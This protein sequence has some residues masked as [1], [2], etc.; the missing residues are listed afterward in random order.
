MPIKIAINGFG[1]IGRPSFR[2]ALGSKEFEVAAINDLTDTKTLAHLL[3][4]DSLYGRFGKKVVYDQN[5]L[6]V[7]GKKYPVYYE[8]EPENLPWE[9]LGVD[10]VLECT[11]KFTTRELA[12]KHLRAGAKAV[13]LSAPPKDSDIPIFIL[14]VNQEKF[15]PQKDK[16]ISNGSC[17]TNCLAP[18]L[19][20]LN[21][22]Y[23]V[24]Y[25]SMTTTHAYTND[26]EL[27]DLPHKDLRRARA[28]AQNIIPTTTGASKSV[29]AVIPELE[30]KLYGLAVR[31]PVPVVSMI[32]LVC[33]VKKPATAEKINDKLRKL[34]QGTFK[35]IVNVTE[36]PLVSS[37]FIG[38][39]HSATVDL[40]LTAVCGKNLV[41]LVAW[42]DNEYGYACRFVEMAE[43]V[44][45]KL[46][47]HLY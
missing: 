3:K 36:E 33:L 6:I 35:G 19:K 32:D 26:Q 1:R 43:Y 7:D 42:Y 47:S 21:D 45:G 25:S 38:D 23:G 29:I 18:L 40:G 10:I 41:K 13:L 2:L 11:G 28:A 15:N 34:T 9:K 5:H 14:G 4:Y 17:T 27:L 46:K 37:D 16:I 24:E 20:I 39:P 8:K 44:G 30:G 31:V 12:E 22:E